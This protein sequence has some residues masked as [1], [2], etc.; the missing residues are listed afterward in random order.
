MKSKLIILSLLLS[1]MY[2][3]TPTQDSPDVVAPVWSPEV[4]Q[5]SELAVIMRAIHQEGIDRKASLEKGMLS[6][7]NSSLI[8][9]MITAQPT[10]PHMVGPAF[11]PHAQGF[12]YS[13]SEIASATSV[14]A[15]I[16]A[17]NNL[18]KSCVA[19]HMNF[20]QGPISRIEKLYIH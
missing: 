1:M 6:T 16:E 12:I 2:A 14:P 19:C 11:E 20:C 5:P 8:F 17:H 15:Q 10:E 4:D 13:Y 7:A 18:V 3:C 9:D